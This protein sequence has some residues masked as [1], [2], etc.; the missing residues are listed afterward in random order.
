MHTCMHS[1]CARRSARN[2]TRMCLRARAHTWVFA[3]PKRV[4]SRE[5]CIVASPLIGHS[6]DC[7]GM[8]R[9]QIYAHIRGNLNDAE[10][11]AA[12]RRLLSG[13]ESQLSR[14]SVG[15]PVGDFFSAL[16]SGDFAKAG[17]RLRSNDARCTKAAQVYEAW[18]VTCVHVRR[19]DGAD[20]G[21]R[22]TAP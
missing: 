11:A 2:L 21:S 3:C 19:L 13:K 6:V 8:A 14:K 12:K 9:T 5:I 10:F 7:T 20:R 17:V 22:G 16:G 1:H 4:P 15:N 18:P